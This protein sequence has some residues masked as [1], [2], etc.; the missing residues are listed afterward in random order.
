MVEAVRPGGQFHGLFDWHCKTLQ[1]K[2]IFWGTKEIQKKTYK[3][4]WQWK[5]TTFFGSFH[6]QTLPFSLHLWGGKIPSETHP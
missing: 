3:L 2:R 4:T 1:L 6:P 5:I